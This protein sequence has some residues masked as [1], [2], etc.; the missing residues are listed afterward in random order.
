MTSDLMYFI[1]TRAGRTL[2]E[3]DIPA[4]RS[5]LERIAAE[6]EKINRRE[7]ERTGNGRKPAGTG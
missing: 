4:I 1:Q 7:D 2:L 6:L 3:S 5:A